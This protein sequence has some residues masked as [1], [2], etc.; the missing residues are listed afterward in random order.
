MPTPHTPNGGARAYTMLVQL[1]GDHTATTANL[2]RVKLNGRHMILGMDAVARA[3]TGT[4]QSCAL[5]LSVDGASLLVAPLGITSTAVTSATMVN[6]P[7]TGGLRPAVAD[8]GVL[9]IGA[10]LAG[11]SPV[12]KDI[13]VSL[14]L[15]RA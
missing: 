8:E 15:V 14:H 11:T 12:Y 3:S 10:T 13:S 2:A 5:T 4:G 7:S 9:S 1:S 6:V